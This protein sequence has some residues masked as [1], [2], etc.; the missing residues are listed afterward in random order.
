MILK[1]LPIIYPKNTIFSTFLI[2]AR[3]I[4]KLG[5]T[6]CLH[7]AADVLQKNDA[8]GNVYDDPDFE[9]LKN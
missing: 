1:Q 5:A 9:I 7:S 4:K 6:V 3:L 2:M 8:A